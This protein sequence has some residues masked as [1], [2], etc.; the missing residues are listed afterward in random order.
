MIAKRTLTWVAAVLG[1][2]LALLPAVAPGQEEKPAAR[3]DP[4]S[5]TQ[6][7]DQA[8]PPQPPTTTQEARQRA[9]ERLQEMRKQASSQ[10]AD[11]PRTAEQIRA[12]RE[13]RR[14]DARKRSEQLRKR[15]LEARQKREADMQKKLDE[16]REGGEDEPVINPVERP[17]VRARNRTPQAGAAPRTD[18][19]VVADPNEAE[20]QAEPMDDPEAAGD[21]PGGD[22]QPATEPTTE[23]RGRFADIPKG[24]GARKRARE[25]AARAGDPPKRGN[26]RREAEDDDDDDEGGQVRPR[27]QAGEGERVLPL[28]LSPDGKTEWFSFFEMPWEEVVKLYAKRIGKPYMNIAD[29]FIIGELTYETTRRFTKLEALD[30]LN[31]LLV[32]QGYFLAETEN[33]VYALPLN[34]L[35]KYL[36]VE[37]AFYP[38]LEAF[39]A[40][41]LRDM[42]FASVL[43]RIKGRPAE[44]IRD[45]IAPAMPDHALPVVLGDTNQIHITGLARD[46]RRFLDLYKVYE[47]EEFDPRE[48]RFIK[49]KTNVREIERML[50]D[51]FDITAAQR[52]YNRQTRK[53]ET[54]GGSDNNIKM[55]PDERTKTLIVKASTAKLTEIEDFIALIDQDPG[56]E[57]DTHVIEVKHGSAVDIANLLNQIFQQEQGT[58]QR[59]PTRTTSRTTSRTRTPTRT[60]TAQNNQAAPEQIIVEDLYERAKKTVRLVADERTNKL[61]VYANKDGL[62]RVNEMLAKI[63]LPVPVNFKT[64]YL[65]YADADQI[66][67][68]VEQFVRG[69][70]TTTT[71]RGR[72]TTSRSGLTIIADPVL[73]ALHVSGEPEEMGKAEEII[74]KLDNELVAE[75]Q[76]VIQLVN[77]TPSRVAQMVS[78]LLSG[79][80]APARGPV[81]RGGRARANA[82]PELIPLDEAGILIVICSDAQWEKVEDTIR[83]WDESALSNQPRDAF[84]QLENASPAAVVEVLNQLYRQYSHPVL[85]R[86]AVLIQALPDDQII[87]HGVQPAIDEI[88][89]L[90]PQLDVVPK[91]NPLVILPLEYADAAQVAELAESLLPTGTRPTGRRGARPASGSEASITPEPVTNSLIVRA[92]DITLD[93][94]KRFAS[95][96]EQAVAQQ[97]PERKFYS[98][99]NAASREVATLVSQLFGAASSRGRGRAAVGTQVKVAAVGTQVVVDAPAMKQAEIGAVIEELDQRSDKGITTKLIKLP[100]APV[101]SIS[102][103]LTAA[104]RDRVRQQGAV[105]VFLDDQTTETILVTCSADVLEEAQNLINEFQSIGQELQWGVEFF[106]LAHANADEAA[107]WLQSQL[108][109]Q[110][111]QSLGTAVARQIKVTGDARTNRVMINGPQTAVRA[112]GEL[113]KNYDLEGQKQPESPI[114]VWTT[115][116]AGVDIRNIANQLKPALDNLTRNR[117]DRLRATASGDQVTN[118]LILSAPKDIRGKVE[119]LVS[120]FTEQSLDLSAEQRFIQL[121]EAEAGYVATQLNNVL[122]RQIERQRGR[123]VAQQIGI[124]ADQRLNQVIINA[125]KFAVEMAE[126]LIKQLDQAPTAESQLHTLALE[127]ADA[128]ALVGVLNTIFREKIRAKTITLS[129]EPLTNSIIVGGSQEEFDGIAEWV[130]ELEQNAEGASSEIVTID[131]NYA[132][133]WETR[134]MINDIFG[135][136]RRQGGAASE[137]VYV[138]VSNNTLVVKAPGSKLE[139][140][141]ALIASIDNQGQD[142]FQ[143]KTYDLQQIDANQLA[144]RINNFLKR[145]AGVQKRGTMQPEAFPEP[146]TNTLVVIASK[147][148]I[149]MIDE[150]IESVVSREAAG[151]VA[152]IDIKYADPWEVRNTVNEIFRTRRGGSPAEQVSVTI[153][154]NTLVVRAPSSKLQDIRDLVARIDVDGSDDDDLQIKTYDLKRLDAQQVSWQV[155]MFLQSMGGNT[156]KGQMKPAAFAEPKTNTLVVIA[157][158][159]KLPLIESLIAGIETKEMPVSEARPYT[160]TNVRADQIARNVEQ[161]LKAKV[162][163]Q[164]GARAQTIQT[165]VM[166]AGAN[167]L[168]VFAPDEYQDMVGELLKMIDS[169]RDTGE[170]VEIVRLEQARAGDVARAV[171]DLQ[172]QGLARGET[173]RV[174]V[175]ADDSSNSVILRGLPAD[176]ADL[177]Q[178]ITSLE[179]NSAN[180]PELKQFQVRYV[181]PYDVQDTLAALFPPTNNPLDNVTVTVDEYYDKVRVTANRR[182]MR[183]VETYIAALDVEPAEDEG[184]AKEIHF[185]DIYRGDPFDIA[186]DVQDLYP[187]DR[188]PTIEADLFGDYIKVVCRPGEFDDI[189]KNIRMFEARAKVERKLKETRLAGDPAKTIRAL[190]LM[191][192]ELRVEYTEA[193]EEA[194]PSTMVETLRKEGDLPESFRKRQEEKRK[195]NNGR[196]DGEEIGLGERRG[197]NVA[198]ASYSDPTIRERVDALLRETYA[199]NVGA[200]G[201]DAVELGE[202]QKEQVGIKVFDDGRILISGPKED[203]EEIESSIDIIESDLGAGEVIR[204]FQFTYGDVTQAARILDLMFNEPRQVVRAPQRQQPNQQQQQQGRRGQEGDDKSGGRGQGGGNDLAA[205]LQSMIGAQRAGG[206][207]G[208]TPTRLRIATDVGNNYL[209]VKCDEARLPEIRELLV[210]LDIPPGEVEIRVYQLRSIDAT[211]AAEN[212][213]SVLG[214]GKAAGRQGQRA[215]A[216]RGNAQQQ[217]LELLEQT[218]VSV[219]GGE[220]AK[221]DTVEIV[222]NAVTNALLVSSPPEVLPIIEDMINELESL[223]GYEIVVIREYPLEAA[224]VD[225]VLPLLQEIFAAAASGG[226]GGGRRGAGSPAQLGTVTV[227]A[228]ARRNVLIYTARQKDVELVERQIALLDV[229]GALAEAEMYV[230]QYGDASSI[231]TAV[232]QIFLIGGGGQRGNRGGGGGVNEMRLSA[233]PSTNTI[234]VYGPAEKRELVFAKVRELDVQA[235]SEIREL[236]IKFAKATKVAESLL[237]IYGGATPTAGGGRRGTRSVSSTPGRLL[238]YGDDSSSKLLVRAPQPLFEQIEQTTR[239]LDQPP[240]LLKIRKFPLVYADALAIKSSLD[241]AIMEYAQ[242]ALRGGQGGELDF[243][244]FTTIPDSRTNSLIVVGSEQTFQFVQLA[245]AEY[246]VPPS[247]ENEATVRLVRLPLGMDAQQIAAEVSQILNEGEMRAAERENRVP[248]LLTI[249]ANTYSN[250]LTVY[251][252]KAQYDVVNNLVSQLQD[253]RGGDEMVTRVVQLQRLTSDEA[254]EIIERLQQQRSNTAGGTGTIRR[255]GGSSTP[256]TFRPGSSRTI[257]P[258][259]NTGGRPPTNRTRGTRGRRP[260]GSLQWELHRNWD[261]ESRP[262][263]GIFTV[264]STRLVPALQRAILASALQENDQPAEQPAQPAER[265]QPDRQPVVVPQ[266]DPAG[267]LDSVSGQL[268]SDVYA[269]PLDSQRIVI[270]GDERDIEFIEQM[271]MLME[272]TAPEGIIEI[273]TLENAK[274]AAIQPIVEQTIQAFISSRTDSPGRADRFSVIAENRSNAL[275]VTASEQNMEMIRQIVQTIDAQT[276]DGGTDFRSFQLKNI[277]AQQAKELLDPVVQKLNAQREVPADQQSSL[278]AIAPSNSLLAIGTPTDLEEIEKMIEAIDQEVDEG[279]DFTTSRVLVM[280]LRNAAANELAE[281][282]TQLIALEAAGGQGGTA[283]LIRQLRLTTAQGQELPPLELDKPIEIIPEPAKNSLIILSSPK[284]NE[285]LKAIV[286]LFDQLPDGH[287]IEIKTMPLQYAAAERVAETLQTLFDEGKEKV[288]TRPQ[289][290]TRSNNSMPP[291]PRTL[292]GNSLPYNVVVK[293]DTRTNSVIVVGRTDAIRLAGALVSEMDQ[294]SVGERWPA[295][296]VSLRNLQA[297]ELQER[298]TEMLDKRAEALGEADNLARDNAILMTD[299]R[300]NSLVVIASTEVFGLVEG[301]A[302][303][304]DDTAS[305]RVVDSRFRRLEY[306]DSV[307]LGNTLQEFFDKKK[308]AISTVNDGG[309][310]EELF[311]LSDSRSNSLLLTGT[312]DFLAEAEQMVS[313]L[314][315][316]YV[317]TLDFRV[318]PVLLNSAA[319]IATRLQEMIDATRDQGEG[320]EGTPIHISADPYSNTL[321]LAASREDMIMVE[322]WVE[323]LDRPSE[324]GRITRIF[325]LSRGDAEAVSTSAGELFQS[326]NEGSSND[327]TVTHDPTTNSVVVSGP[328]QVVR[329]VEDFLARIDTTEP[330]DNGSIQI[331]KLDQADAETAGNLLRSIVALESGTIDSSGLR[332]SGG[333]NSAEAAS[334]IMLVWH[335]QHADLGTETLKAMRNGITVID[336]VRTNQ[337]IVI[338][339]TSSMP[340]IE[341]LVAAIDVPPDAAK[342]RIF[343]LRNSDAEQMVE[344]LDELF[345]TEQGGGGGAAGS[346]TERILQLE[347]FA[348]GGRQELSFTTDMRTNS[349][350]A[351][352]TTG[353]LDLVEELILKLDTQDIQSRTTLVYT[354]HN[355]EAAAIQTAL[356][357]L[358]DAEQQMLADLQEDLSVSERMGRE[359]VAVAS[360]DTNRVILN[361]DPRRRSELLSLVQDLDQPPPQV[362][363]QVLIAEVMLNDSLELGVE[364]AFQDLQF[365]KAGPGDTN[366]FDFVGGTDLGAAGAGLGGFTFT[367][368]GQDFNFL[369]RTLQNEGTLNVLQRPQIMAMDNLEARIEITN[370]VP[371]VSGTQTSTTGQISTAVARQDVGIILEVTPRINPDGFVNMHV[372]QEVSDLTDSTVDVGQGVTAPIFFRREAETDVTVRNNETVVLGGLIS[373]TERTVEQKIPGLGDVPVVGL[374]FRNNEVSSDHTELLVVLTPRVVRT[375]EDYRELSIRERDLTGTIPDTVL[376]NPLMQGLRVRPEDL[377]PLEDEG[378]LEPITIEARRP[379]PQVPVREPAPALRDTPSRPSYDIPVSNKRGA[380]GNGRQR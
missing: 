300:S 371:Y 75:T 275:F 228:D 374:L 348:S 149:P 345:A 171:S 352:G 68:L 2:G 235:S 216:A 74:A 90:L 37:Q 344:M 182:R 92:D 139:E 125:P 338:A 263:G 118:T 71:I 227:A 38:N 204:I 363:I 152:T 284:N 218:Q 354:P 176:I 277:R 33:Y 107:R 53:W 128:R 179:T 296:V 54:T 242:M 304:L 237:A 8:K 183:Q 373:T 147:R 55:I 60:N 289:E 314:D 333:S 143:I 258:S 295:R 297:A 136:S 36:P 94:I 85:G 62:E 231:A 151:T 87:V 184:P 310:T 243:D 305:Y 331:F 197:P 360:E 29:V 347:G 249:G 287:D 105:A 121:E 160:L 12:E 58:Q 66:Q 167:Q 27:N 298:L 252:S 206:S 319:G 320:M 122:V 253:V 376:T 142:D 113:L 341:S 83:I 16:Q 223:S 63:D 302:R 262:A 315:Q 150:L 247:E 126:E 99:K 30:E 367:I 57:F 269:T 52:T 180:V 88:E 361:F 291:Q 193:G 82:T 212:I 89:A 117:P 46:V 267:M 59:T 246:D 307:K 78:P 4:V 268:R 51:Y 358:N 207:D 274:A 285:A 220:G 261:R 283:R 190:M 342:I 375:V 201:Q 141:K 181:S 49:I 98:L 321:L 25:A 10:P 40:A 191:H 366:T 161:M 208:K 64:F 368:S 159:D 80:A 244:P 254:R 69:T 165:A 214:I 153:S 166:Q 337:L 350:I 133:P 158:A 145:S 233:E 346:D 137:D 110:M 299:E 282:L 168:V 114:E 178:Q 3:P 22:D 170:V 369:L 17:D 43:I 132:D 364:F 311:V 189:L 108:V 56:F 370:D 222:P 111:G 312:R 162:A 251:G 163:E 164:E 241:G 116:L 97:Q 70:S 61:I 199:I 129:A 378:L 230:C 377:R 32:Q 219:G 157:P 15:A 194:A 42:E 31:F 225:D 50:Q 356:Q 101:R 156:K 257:R 109:A 372:R 86:S 96:M 255:T 318:R 100:G 308:D 286:G 18:P 131:L 172:R 44:T 120:K 127:K 290:N 336:N 39:E 148:Q 260:G 328:P 34:E 226:G 355:N 76:H 335:R 209:I 5:D 330:V 95:E 211:E 115:P 175:V 327:V 112:G 380:A 93:R 146:L 365:T 303:Q 21:E 339:P 273:F 256:S 259:G 351:A 186:W 173:A 239:T 138:T 91:E 294:P 7:A 144:G 213:K 362:M 24:G 45:M 210:E 84:F 102:Q 224:K 334:Q 309:Q 77:L 280:D 185:V 325:P 187:L 19:K 26:L 245:I 23:R 67:P 359:I 200:G 281:T 192:P 123:G 266:G 13:Q 326:A 9:L 240:E 232:S 322:R 329:D 221:V 353:Y 265:P 188:G 202:P 48:T 323:V 130:R 35:G 155:S 271:L 103:K 1:A 324:P 174:A 229:E 272:A 140:V 106:D 72:S 276:E 313:Q 343:P 169:D 203:V 104:F 217:I 292:T 195:R 332:S 215:P 124:V 306:A 238:I 316:S 279:N 234:L 379:E 264:T 47:T 205:Q 154:N 248:N 135:R 81:R 28:P 250:A 301:L 119:E 198:L 278:E 349:V 270:T 14:E 357:Q 79:G 6:P 293:S 41:N 20:E 196:E 340:L 177:Q 73:N 65:D 288:L 134:N 236:D 11:A 317:P